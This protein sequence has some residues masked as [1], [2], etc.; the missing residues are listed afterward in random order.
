[1][2]KGL[3]Y[4]I[5]II[6]VIAI[7]A[8]AYK[9]L[10]PSVSVPVTTTAPSSANSTV[11]VQ[12]TDPPA[13]PNG[14]QALMLYYSNIELHAAGKSNSTG[15]VSLNA[16]GSVNLM[17]L[18]NL[19]QTVGVGK[20]SKTANFDLLRLNISGATITIGN[21]TYNVSVPNNRL[22]VR[23]SSLMNATSPTALIDFYPSVLQIYAANQTI[24][25]LVP[26]LKGV[27]IKGLPLNSTQ[28]HVGAKARIENSARAE[29]ERLTPNITITQSKLSVQNTS[30]DFSVTV[31]DN[32][33]SS[34]MV[35]DVMLSGYMRR[36][37][38]IA[39][40]I[41]RKAPPRFD[42]SSGGFGDVSGGLN[43][44]SLGSLLGS[45]N[46]S[47]MNFTNMSSIV[48][49]LGNVLSAHGINIS[50][51][52]GFGIGNL[53]NSSIEDLG[54]MLKSRM[55]ASVLE[56]IRNINISN[57]SVEGI[58]HEVGNFSMNYHNVL[59]FIVLGNG[60][61]S[62]PFDSAEFE[63]GQ[64]NGQN[65]YNLS[66]GSSETFGFSGTIGFG[67]SPIRILPLVNQTYSI[68][69]V[70]EEGA[71]ASANVTAG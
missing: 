31:K 57:A 13:V 50:D 3:A 15:F 67:S 14:T 21:A 24:F 46:L 2:N 48:S 45:L 22:L 30:V 42:S 27:V 11:M 38:P 23:L 19:T 9:A 33:N 53:S 54:N 17:N 35:K 63:D 47:G 10:V 59:N 66:A 32:S 60:T 4:A 18:T 51:I 43:L 69:V 36:L 49:S 5:G 52:H 8:V 1:M 39:M 71:R 34:V 61:L 55:N 6:I 62:L 26:S 70:G 40:P 41:V 7:A 65:G 44:G 68:R 28:A 29:I 25:V 12:L 20:V 37:G 58:L 56:D 16:S 64:Q